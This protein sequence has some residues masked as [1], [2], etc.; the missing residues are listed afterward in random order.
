MRRIQINGVAVDDR[1]FPKPSRRITLPLVHRFCSLVFGLPQ[2]GMLSLDGF[3]LAPWVPDPS[4]R[5]P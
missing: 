4:S 3:T 2:S 5:F 1:G